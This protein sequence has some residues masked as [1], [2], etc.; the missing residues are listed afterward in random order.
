M[1][2]TVKSFIGVIFLLLLLTP[3]AFAD[4]EYVDGWLGTWT[5]TMNDQSTVTWEITDTWVSDTGRSH[6]AYGIKNPDAV[7]FQIYFSTLL[8]NKYYY[9]EADH[10]LTIYDLPNDLT[11]YTELVPAENF[12]T[13]SA[14]PGKYPIDSGYKGTEP[15]GPCVASYL[16]GADDPRLAIVRK[17][18]DEKMAASAAGSSLIEL[19]YEMS[20]DLINRCENNPAE[21]FSLKLMLEAAIPIIYTLL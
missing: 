4:S 6:V 2:K 3:C 14:Q 1:K 7:E 15:P 9:I 11:Q 13:F 19:Y 17:F 5:V 18:R 21:K 8:D 16:L 12:A 20:D 10:D